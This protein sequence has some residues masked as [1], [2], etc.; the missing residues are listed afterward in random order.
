M[1]EMHRSFTWN[2]SIS[3]ETGKMET[4]VTNIRTRSEVWTGSSSARSHV[5]LFQFTK[6]FDGQV[7]SGQVAV[8]AGIRVTGS[9]DRAVQLV[10]WLTIEQRERL[11]PTHA[12]T[13]RMVSLSTDRDSI[14][15]THFPVVH[16]VQGFI[17]FLVV[18]WKHYSWTKE[19]FMSNSERHC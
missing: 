5:F 17:D 6:D 2:S 18:H 10:F 15:R 19:Q 11:F 16:A 14:G 7:T 12:L 1:N 8:A 4:Q 3:T 9:L 13:I